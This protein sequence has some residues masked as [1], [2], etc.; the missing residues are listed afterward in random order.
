L[1]CPGK[2][3]AKTVFAG[4]VKTMEKTMVKTEMEKTCQP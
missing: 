4:M 2:N 1:P 3:L